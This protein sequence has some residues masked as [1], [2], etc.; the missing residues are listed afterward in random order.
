[1]AEQNRHPKVS[2]VMS[3]Y[4]GERH[5]RETV[6]SV[7]NQTF[8]D[9]E[10][11][12]IDDGS[13]DGT[14]AI[15]ESYDD[16]RIV[17]LHNEENIGLTRSLNRGLAKAQGEYIARQ[18][19]DDVSF[20]RR[21]AAQVQF[22]DSNP[23][24]G[25]VGT[26][27]CRIDSQGE[28]LGIRKGSYGGRSLRQVLHRRS[29]FTHGSVMFRQTCLEVVGPYRP[30]FRYAQD[31]DLWLRISEHFD[32]GYVEETLYM[33]RVHPTNIT[34]A[35][36]PTQSRFSVLARELA[37][38]RAQGTDED[39]EAVAALGQEIEEGELSQNNRRIRSNGHAFYARL[40]LEHG[41]RR[42]ALWHLFQ[43][44]AID[45]LNPNAWAF[46]AQI[47]CSIVFARRHFSP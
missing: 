27:C 36:R 34:Y 30:C 47:L 45:C 20:A 9:F 2:V 43:A 46:A 37:R 28:V 3:V 10:F 41:H 35:R 23:R 11:I 15:L 18:D 13:T 29:V 4:N 17:L 22:L 8:T 19:A 32:L 5:L 12:M 14:R 7:L 25:L 33:R 38:Q 6:E 1:M 21:L 26:S 31:F 40:V 44:M 42:K 24:V 39:L 16:S